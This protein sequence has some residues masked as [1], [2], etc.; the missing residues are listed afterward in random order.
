MPN[1]ARL[2]LGFVVGVVAV[3]TFHQFTVFMI[4]ALGLAPTRVY[5]WAANPWGVPTIINQC[6]WGGL[7]GILFVILWDRAG[8][9]LPGWLFGI[10]FG[11]LGPAMVNFIVLPLI[12]ST[13]LFAGFVPLR[14]LVTALIGA[15][16]GL[17]L[18]VLLPLVA[19]FMRAA[20][21]RG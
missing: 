20:A 21:G 16:F 8:S 12:R 19:R 5:Q 11:V 17:G 13:P 15:M 4:G 14:M 7:W 10:V 3:L 6:F 2:A 1:P 9:R 18:A